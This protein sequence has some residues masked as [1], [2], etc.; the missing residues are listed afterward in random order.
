MK[1]PS[2]LT[3]ADK[4]EIE[5]AK[6]GAGRLWCIDPEDEKALKWLFEGAMLQQKFVRAKR[7][8]GNPWEWTWM[9]IWQR[10]SKHD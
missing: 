2:Q 3:P 8:V 9:G 5:R 10:I 7:N 1:L 6:A 4:K